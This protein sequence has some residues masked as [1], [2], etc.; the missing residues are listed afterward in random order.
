MGAVEVHFTVTFFTFVRRNL[1]LG[2]VALLV[3]P[4]FYSAIFAD[5]AGF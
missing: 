4:R 2:E 5:L 1:W 3:Q